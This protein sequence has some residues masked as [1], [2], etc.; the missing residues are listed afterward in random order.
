VRVENV[1]ERA[2]PTV[3]Y[4]SQPHFLAASDLPFPI[5]ENVSENNAAL[6]LKMPDEYFEL[7][8]NTTAPSSKCDSI[9][10]GSHAKSWVIAS[11][12]GD[13]RLQRIP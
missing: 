12:V 1:S 6:N 8:S 3:H 13:N 4:G 7:W 10:Q 11:S 9:S 2:C 5:F